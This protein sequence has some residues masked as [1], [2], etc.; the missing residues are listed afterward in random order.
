MLALLGSGVKAFFCVADSLLIVPS[1]GG[2]RVREL[3]GVLFVVRSCLVDKVK[4]KVTQ[5]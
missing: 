1:H 4:V 3:P 5:P 2:T